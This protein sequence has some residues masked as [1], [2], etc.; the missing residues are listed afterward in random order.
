MATEIADLYAKLSLVS[1]GFMDGLKTAGTEAET[2]GSKIAGLGATA[3]KGLTVAGAGVAAVSVKMAG[4]WQAS[5]IKLVTSAGET[6]SVVDGK[7]TGPIA[8]VSKQLLQMAVDTGTSTKELASGMYYVESAGFH[9]ADGLTVMKMAAEGAKAEGADLHT[10]ADALTTALHDMGAKASDSTAYMDMMIK[11]VASG[12]T[13]MEALAG[14]LHSVLPQAS[15]AHISFADIGAAIATMTVAGTSADQATMMLGHTITTLE[16]PNALAIKSMSQMGLS[17]T[18]LAKNLGTRGLLGTFAMIDEAIL[19]HMGPDGLALQSAFNKSQSAAQDLGIMLNAMP[20]SLQKLSQELQNGTITATNYS[21]ATKTMPANL[22][23]Q[24]QEFLTLYKNSSSFNQALRAG[25]PDAL[26]FAAELK[27]V[28]GDSVTMNTVMQAGGANL[29]TFAATEKYVGE[30]AHEASG[31]IETWGAITKGFNFQMDQMRQMIETTAIKIGTVMLPRL[32]Q[33]AGYLMNTVVPTLSH[34]GAGLIAAFES[35]GAKAAEAAIVKVFQD[36]VKFASQ[37]ITSMDNLYHAIEPTANLLAHVFLGALIGVGKILVDVIGP[38]VMA[39]T[40]F[41]SDNATLIRDVAVVALTALGVKLLYVATLAAVDMF[42]NFYNG[43]SAAAVGIQKFMAA[44]GSGAWLDTLKLKAMYAGDALKGVA[45]SEEMAASSGLAAAGERGMGGLMGTLGR[46]LP[47]IGAVGLGLGM[48]G[49]KLNEMT[50]GGDRTSQDITKLTTALVGLNN[51][52]GPASASMMAMA[53]Q[54]FIMGFKMHTTVQGMKDFDSSLVALVN[55]G[56]TADAAAAFQQLTTY[57]QQHGASIKDV[58]NQL[59]GYEHAL[60]TLGL[61]AKMAASATQSQTSALGPNT[62]ALQ[63]DTTATNNLNNATGTLTNTTASFQGQ[64]QKQQSLDQF[65]SAMQNLT[66]SV[67]LNGQALDANSA[68]GI[69]NRQA[70]SAAASEI[71]NYYQQ[72]M[73]AQ[74]PIA[75]AT[76]D[77]NNQITALYN[78]AYKAFPQ[79]KAAVDSYLSSLGLIKPSYTTNVNANVSGAL[80]NISLVQQRLNNLL[81]TAGS[82]APVLGHVGIYDKGG[83]VNAPKG[84]PVPAVVHGGEYVITAEEMAGIGATSPG[85]K[86]SISAG[87]GGG[88]VQMVFNIQGSVIAERDLRDLV[89]TQMLQLGARNSASYQPYKR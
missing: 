74:V 8:N 6:G 46:S 62:T 72:Q 7:L 26:T 77:M 45:T 35:P 22:Q 29:A 86:M 34:V 16:A 38:A 85:G 33:F 60:S 15:A 31:H 54:M 20:P 28:T 58:T 36:V 13:S 41:L 50:G 39:F 42:A 69:G 71:A 12:K 14:S 25:T 37:V 55:N 65:N 63:G 18:D 10:V 70:M 82:T 1:T 21:I 81:I 30:S 84:Q 67:Q 66:S 32:T 9:G 57:A 24:G 73:Q 79:S 75:T 48:L 5:M 2:F 49:T 47:I 64:L 43:I 61:N 59:P 87:G 76:S 78:Q 27:K 80:Y 17:A 19:K 23:A 56:H 68:A 3:V 53:D 88:G 40:R 11:T 4:D 51:A 83:F 44:V 89:Q 52:S